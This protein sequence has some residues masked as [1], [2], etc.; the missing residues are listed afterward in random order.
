MSESGAHPAPDDW[1]EGCGRRL[2]IQTDKLTWKVIPCTH[3]DCDVDLL[4]NTFYAP[5]KGR[6][7][8]HST[9]SKKAIASSHLVKVSAHTESS[10]SLAKIECPLCGN[11][12][13][14]Q[15]V[16]ENTGNVVFRCTDG[17]DLTMKDIQGLHRQPCMTVIVIKPG[18]AWAEQKVYPSALRDL[19][20]DFNVS[21]RVNYYDKVEARN[22]R[23]NAP[24]ST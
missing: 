1:F 15:R 16:D 12:L 18:M 17:I 3:A 13:L 4:V 7:E 19:I 9:S 8:A 23:D 5:S 14:V 21:Q 6:C 20:E 10:G 22:E 24:A 11:P 2:Q